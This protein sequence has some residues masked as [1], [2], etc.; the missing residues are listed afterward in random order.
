[1]SA[2][3]SLGITFSFFCP[4]KA[5]LS[6]HVVCQSVGSCSLLESRPFRDWPQPLVGAPSLHS[7]SFDSWYLKN[8]TTYMF[9]SYS[10]TLKTLFLPSFMC[11][12]SIHWVSI[13]GTGVDSE[14]DS[15]RRSQWHTQKLAHS[16]IPQPCPVFW[17][18]TYASR[19]I[20]ER[21]W[22]GVLSHRI[23]PSKIR[24]WVPWGREWESGWEFG[25]YW[26]LW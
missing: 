6:N 8:S 3:V 25:R 18:L 20:P 16:R 11:S 21:L 22:A 13:R 24:S 15:G 5:I 23:G 10:L 7:S 17:S 19:K 1:M 2:S 26:G 9:I 4:I 14:E 12:T